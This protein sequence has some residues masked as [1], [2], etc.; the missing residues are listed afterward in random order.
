MKAQWRSFATPIVAGM[1]AIAA[2]TAPLLAQSVE[3]P[4]PI[5]CA[6]GV[7]CVGTSCPDPCTGSKRCSGDNSPCCCFPTGQPNSNLRTCTC[8]AWGT[9]ESTAPAGQ[10]CKGTT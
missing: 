4:E 5:P 1:F 9:C 8:K 2:M 3:D 6:E 10:T 7:N